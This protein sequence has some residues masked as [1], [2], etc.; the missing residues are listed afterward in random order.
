MHSEPA[1]FDPYTE[2]GQPLSSGRQDFDNVAVR[3]HTW[4]LKLMR[5]MGM[6]ST[7][8]LLTMCASD[9]FDERAF[10]HNFDQGFALV[11]FLIDI[12]DIAGCVFPLEGYGYG[13]VDALEPLRILGQYFVIE[14]CI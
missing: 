4:L 3:R 9:L 11:S 8:I 13:V 2:S 10:A 6:S 1:Y 12:S 5:K 14:A 7:D